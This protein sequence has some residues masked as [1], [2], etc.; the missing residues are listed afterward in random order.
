MREIDRWEGGAGWI[1][2]PEETMQRASH[3]LATDAGVFLVDP[4]DAEGVDDLAASFGD[5]SGVVVSLDRHKRDAAAIARRHGVPV[6]VPSW[7]DGVEDELDAP[8][9]R[10]G[11]AIPGT[12]YEV[13][14]LVNNR[15]WQE[16]FLYDGS[17]LLVPEALGTI[18]YFRT[19][20]E[21]LGVHPMLRMTP[22]TRLRDL[23][24]DRLLVGHG[25]GL[26][27][28]VGPAVSDAVDNARRRAPG[29][30]IENIRHFLSG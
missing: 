5:V 2:Y 4:V 6:H 21:R 27:E 15:L 13:R 25:A 12:D 28:N 1:A 3:V 16:A 26:T 22:P 11:G 18:D 24:A 8:T 17:T 7:M 20:R 9:E 29:L 23:S 10:L 30:L 14:R 19:A